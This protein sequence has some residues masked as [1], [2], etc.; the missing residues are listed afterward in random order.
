MI[1]N[2]HDR[3]SCGNSR[4]ICS[5]DIQTDT[6]LREQGLETKSFGRA[7]HS[8]IQIS[9]PADRREL[10]GQARKLSHTRQH[11]TLRRVRMQML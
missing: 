4:L 5:T 3:T 9:H 11:F 7:L 10:A 2:N 6:H 1:G 8:P